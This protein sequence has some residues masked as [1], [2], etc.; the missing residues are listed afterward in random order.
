MDILKNS[1]QTLL[2]SSQKK[3][4]ISWVGGH[5]THIDP[6]TALSPGES[7]RMI[8]IEKIEDQKTFENTMRLLKDST[9]HIEYECMYGKKHKTFNTCA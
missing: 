3:Y 7:I 8:E 1:N 4:P 2:A 9:V 5:V 6:P